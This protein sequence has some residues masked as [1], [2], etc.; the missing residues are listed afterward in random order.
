MRSTQRVF[1]SYFQE[2]LVNRKKKQHED[3]GALSE[4]RLKSGHVDFY[5]LGIPKMKE[6][7]KESKNI[8]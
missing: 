8:E 3:G 6:Q 4:E 7:G 1:P 2:S 5:Y